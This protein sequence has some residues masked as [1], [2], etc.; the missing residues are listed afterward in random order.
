MAY[1]LTNLTEVD[2]TSY[3]IYIHGLQILLVYMITGV[4]RSLSLVT[5][6]TVCLQPLVFF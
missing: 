6:I 2:K 4:V 1:T 3:D 5:I